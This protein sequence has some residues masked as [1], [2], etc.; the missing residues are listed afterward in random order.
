MAVGAFGPD[1]WGLLALDTPVGP[2]Q[3]WS[4][5]HYIAQGL[6][7]AMLGWGVDHCTGWLPTRGLLAGAVASTVAVGGMRVCRR[8]Y[9]W[10]VVGVP[11]SFLRP[12][13]WHWV[14]DAAFHG[15]LLGLVV[16]VVLELATR[17]QEG[18]TEAGA[19]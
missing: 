2:P 13:W 11:A 7:G 17:R 12:P 15:A 9:Y 5:V 19:G 6:L 16:G 3:V 8:L 14:A 4:A 18:A 10:L 1:N